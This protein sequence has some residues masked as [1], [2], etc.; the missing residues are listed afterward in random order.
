MRGRR[1]G[2]LNLVLAAVKRHLGAISRRLKKRVEALP[3]TKLTDLTLELPRL[4]SVKH[5]TAFLD[6]LE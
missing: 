1:L 6:D 2:E 5:L 3:L 4:T